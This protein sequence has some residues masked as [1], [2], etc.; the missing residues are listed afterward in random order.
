MHPA[1]LIAT[2]FYAAMA[3]LFVISLLSW[4][5]WN[6]VSETSTTKTLL[7]HAVEFLG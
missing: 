5:F 3:A 7:K 6:G 4:I 2:L 1:N